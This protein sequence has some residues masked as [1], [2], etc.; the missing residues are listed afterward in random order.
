MDQ[1]KITLEFNT[2]LVVL[3]K[4]LHQTVIYDL[5]LMVAELVVSHSLNKQDL[6]LVVTETLIMRQK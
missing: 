5:L 6:S 4:Y 1:V 2:Q 3:V